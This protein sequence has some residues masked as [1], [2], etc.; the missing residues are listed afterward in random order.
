MKPAEI[1]HRLLDIERAV[2]DLSEEVRVGLAD[3]RSPDALV[4]LLQD[5]AGALRD[6]Q[7]R[8]EDLTRTCPREEKAAIQN[9]L[10]DLGRRFEKLVEESKSNYQRVAQVGFRLTGIGGKSYTPKRTPAGGER[11]T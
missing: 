6:F 3:G 10:E 1:L 9:E 4:P 8:L 7:A 11:P 5:Q 2:S